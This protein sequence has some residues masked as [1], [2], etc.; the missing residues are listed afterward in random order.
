MDQPAPRGS[1]RS[2][3][4]LAKAV[5][6]EIPALVGLRADDMAA[7]ELVEGAHERVFFEVACLSEQIEPEVAAHCC[8]NF[9][10]RAGGV[11]QQR[12]ARRDDALHFRPHALA[13]RFLLRG[14]LHP[15]SFDDEQGMPFGF[16]KGPRQRRI[17][18]LMS[19]HLAGELR[20]GHLV[21]RAERDR[22]HE[23]IAL[24]T[25]EQPTQGRVVLLLLG[26][27]GADDE[28]VHVGGRAHEILQ[29]VQGVAVGPL[30]IVDDENQRS[31]RSECL[32]ERLE[33]AQLLPALQLRGGGRD[34]GPLR[35]Y[36]PDEPGRR[37][38]SRSDPVSPVRAA[39]LRF[40]ASRR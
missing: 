7:P 39:A 9:R 38:S 13:W 19:G 17:I 6:A 15:S 25:S 20:G 1:D 21:E 27:R 11:R 29:P 22:G 37:Q 2:V 4:D 3:G 28:A 14:R 16:V 33:E 26:A 23:V 34:L 18:E 10:G 40:S 24:E 31:G 32:R 36:L 30:Q 8:G 35:E 12:Q 5:V